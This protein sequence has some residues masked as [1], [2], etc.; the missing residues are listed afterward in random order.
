MI[1]Y[2]V[3]YSFWTLRCNSACNIRNFQACRM[4]KNYGNIFS[5]FLIL[6]LATVSIES[7][8]DN[9]LEETS[10]I[11]S[12]RLRNMGKYRLLDDIANKEEELISLENNLQ[13]TSSRYGMEINAEKQTHSEHCVR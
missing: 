4:I 11:V 1:L 5:P 3:I 7:V 9:T 13:K 8:L 2:H 6:S 12:V 10:V